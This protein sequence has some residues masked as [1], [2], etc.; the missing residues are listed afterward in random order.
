MSWISNIIQKLNP[1][2]EYIADSYPEESTTTISVYS[3]TQAYDYV[4][5]V[6]WVVDL[7]VDST[8]F[9]SYDIK[10]RI[11]GGG[12]NTIKPTK[13]NTLINYKPNPYQ[14]ANEFKRHLV[15]DFIIEGNAFIYYDGT[16]L[17]HLPANSV[18]VVSDKKTY[19][20]EYKV[21]DISYYPDEI[22]KISDQSASNI[23]RGDSRL[24]YSLDMINLLKTMYE[25]HTTLYSNSA[26]PGMVIKTDDMLSSKMKIR[27]LNE[28]SM[29]YNP[30]AGGKRP[31]ILDG[32]MEIASLGDTHLRELDFNDSIKSYEESVLENLGIPPILLSSG[33]NSNV[34]P[35]EKLFYR[36]TI[37]PICDKIA[38]GFELFFGYDIK[39][40]TGDISALKS[41]LKDQANYYSTLV[42]N[43]I[44]TASEARDELRL[45]DLKD[46]SLESVR[47]PANIAGSA[48]GDTTGG[49]PTKETEWIKK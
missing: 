37:L 3:V 42:N 48:A 49:A 10:D 13:L 45:K 19:I 25:F 39:P 1:S 12:Q 31:M 14:S 46:T 17:Y 32:G 11:I 21:G 33:N 35:N 28:W 36:Q 7:I 26:I 6:G 2:Q 47:I 40:V 8:S 23:F 16:Y 43:G 30:K 24:L 34:S 18:E 4:C 20:K 27:M 29:K 15:L 44:M 41:D 5:V 22:I 9:V 38:A